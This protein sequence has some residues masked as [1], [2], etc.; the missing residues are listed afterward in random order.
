MMPYYYFDDDLSYA[1]VI[2][3]YL[4]YLLMYYFREP[5]DNN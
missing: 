4:Y 1:Q 2:D 3:S 5:I